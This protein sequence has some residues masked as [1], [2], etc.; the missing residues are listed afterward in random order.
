[1]QAMQAMH[2][3]QVTAALTFEELRLE[4][5]RVRRRRLP[6][7][8]LQHWISYLPISRDDTGRYDQNDAEILKALCRW[9]KTPGRT[10]QEFADNLKREINQDAY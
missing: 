9:L 4:V 1:M 2:T 8:T 3:V 10:I 7:R 5:E 6:P